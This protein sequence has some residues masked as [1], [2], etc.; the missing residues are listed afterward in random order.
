MPERDSHDS[1]TALI[2]KRVAE[3][4]QDVLGMPDGTCDGTFF[5]LRGQSISAVRIT[6][7]IEDDLGIVVDVGVLF[8]DPDLAAFTREVLAARGAEGV[9]AGAGD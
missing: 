6:G 3:I 5:Q 2:E 4:W 9:A 1:S 8:E 7:R